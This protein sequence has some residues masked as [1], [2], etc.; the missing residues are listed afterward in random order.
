MLYSL[1]DSCV[2]EREQKAQRKAKDPAEGRRGL[3]HGWTGVERRKEAVERPSQ[4]LETVHDDAD[5][6]EKDKTS[7]LSNLK[8]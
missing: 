7:I 6:E 4:W 1:V 3:G 8:Y 5:D 2:K